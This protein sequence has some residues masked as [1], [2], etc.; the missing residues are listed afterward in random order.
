MYCLAA[1]LEVAVGF[2]VAGVNNS[3]WVVLVLGLLEVVAVEVRVAQEDSGWVRAHL[4][5]S[6]EN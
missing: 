1:G 5:S 4:N 3:A 6:A 2:L